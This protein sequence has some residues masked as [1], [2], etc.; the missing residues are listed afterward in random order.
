MKE[1]MTTRF[2]NL[3]GQDG[4]VV[5]PVVYDALAAKLAEQA[6]FRAISHG[7]HATAASLLGQPDMGLV[8]FKEMHDRVEAIARAVNVP[9]FSDAD[10][11][12][13]N[14]I[15]V[16]RTVKEYIR[17]G[18]AGLF[19]EDQTWPKKCGYMSGKQVIPLEDM[20]NKIK[21]ARDTRDEEDPDFVLG[22]R[23]DAIATDGIEE[24]IRRARAYS[25]VGI[26]FVYIEGYTNISQMQKAL[27]EVDIPLLAS[28]GPGISVVKTVKEMERMGFKIVAFPLT[29]LYAA[30]KTVRD[31]LQVLR[32]TGSEQSILDRLTTFEEFQDIVGLPKMMEI[33][34]KY[35]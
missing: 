24:A 8:C 23:T 33:E 17:A 1:K 31:V 25:S 13:G 26:D 21:A 4:V 30:A 11:G 6:G 18:A 16:Y 2:R 5:L 29:T 7:G 19:I 20:V 15:N 9:V 35:K 28:M 12:Y 32:Q 22:A 34:K 10:T 14:P 3:L 27:R